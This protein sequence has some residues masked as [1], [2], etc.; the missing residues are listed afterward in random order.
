MKRT[1]TEQKVLKKLDIPDFRHVTKDKLIAFASLLP[2][3]E[4]EVAKKALE[5]FPNFASTSLEVMKN[6]K[7]MLEQALKTNSESAHACMQLYNQVMDSL[8]KML[9]DD[10]LSFDDKKYVLNQ[11]VEVAKLADKKDT[12]TQK[13]TLKIVGVASFVV[14]GVVSALASALGSNTVTKSISDMDDII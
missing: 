7:D 14:L 6:Y 11:M 1:L 9:E 10:E 2:Q 8:Q 5:Q 12:E 4:P 13:T 3:M